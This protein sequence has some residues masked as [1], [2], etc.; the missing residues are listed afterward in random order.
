M[1]RAQRTAV[2]TC[3]ENRDFPTANLLQEILDD[4]EKRI[5]FLFE[6][7]QGHQTQESTERTGREES[8]PPMVARAA[9]HR[10]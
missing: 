7:T 4:T 9:S 8:T 10:R 1:A 2:T 3:E 5:W 6:V